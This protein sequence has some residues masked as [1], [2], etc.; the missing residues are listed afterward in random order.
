MK[1]SGV[2]M[3]MTKQQ[4]VLRQIMINGP[5]SKKELQEVSDISWGMISNITTQLLEEKYIE[6]CVRETQGVGRKAEEYDIRHDQ[7]L[8][9]G[10]DFNYNGMLAVIADMKGRVLEQQERQFEVREREY[11]LSQVFEVVD[12][13]FERFRDREILGI[14]FAIQG[15]VDIYEGISVLISAIDGWEDVPLRKIVEERYG[16]NVF[17]E[18]DPN[19]IMR[20]EQICGCL[21]RR[22]VEEVVLVNH[23][24]RIGAGMSIMTR[25]QICH[26]FHGKAGEIGTMPVDITSEGNY[27]YMEGHMTKEGL[28]R[29][30]KELTGKEITYR[31][32]QELL[33]KNDD[34]CLEIYHRLGEYLGFAMGTAANFLNPQVAIVH[35]SGQK[36]KYLHNRILDMTKRIFYDKTIEVQLSML[37][38]EAKAVGAALIVSEYAIKQL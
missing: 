23:D 7:H 10:I 1:Y 38:Q 30:Y 33:Q 37:G 19:C 14:G 2:P 3:Q 22:N 17:L 11:A 27:R 25:G 5:V 18:H 12:S 34:S 6:S 21:K 31:E 15:I 13:F 29:D 26:G 28:L 9:I 32:F 16:V 8:C 20:C 36:Q 35:L 4:N 24:P